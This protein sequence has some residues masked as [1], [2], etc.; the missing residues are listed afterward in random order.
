MFSIDNAVV[1]SEEDFAYTDD[2]QVFSV[3]L[4]DVIQRCYK[5]NICYIITALIICSGGIILTFSGTDLNLVP[6]SLVI[7]IIDD[8]DNTTTDVLVERY[9]I[10][11]AFRKF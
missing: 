7:D 5:I 4:N 3:T 1:E 2:Q 9:N 8:V 11:S 6:T 10:V